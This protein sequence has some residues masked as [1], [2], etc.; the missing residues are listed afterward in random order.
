MKGQKR[1]SIPAPLARGRERFQAWRQERKVGSRIPDRLWG[2]AVKL[3]ATHGI[4]RTAAVLGVDYY[5]LKKHMDADTAGRSATASNFV[6]LPPS[7]LANSGGEC[8]I[9]LEDTAGARMRV[10]LKGYDA[11]D[12]CALGRS[13]W[14]G[15]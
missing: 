15:D 10:Y 7:S 14:N 1:R 12:L 11:P 13:F 2:L 6:E 9:E 3:A 4:C 5:S 8:T